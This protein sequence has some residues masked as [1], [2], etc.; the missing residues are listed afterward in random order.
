MLPRCGKNLHVDSGNR[1]AVSRLHCH[2]FAM[3]FGN[4][5]KI[6]AVAGSGLI[7]VFHVVAMIDEV[8]DLDSI[9]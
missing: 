8:R 6:F 5:G 1:N 2:A 9:G 3:H 4:G 7:G